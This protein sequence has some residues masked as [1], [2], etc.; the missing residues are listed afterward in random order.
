M[1]EGLSRWLRRGKGS[2]STAKSRLQLILIHDRTGISPEILESLREDIF[3]IISK[4]F[5]VKE[6]DVEMSLEK[7]ED[8]VALVANIPVLSMKR[9]EKQPVSS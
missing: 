1:F 5:V 4:Y 8:A 9:Q 3:L 2:K 6:D 7:D